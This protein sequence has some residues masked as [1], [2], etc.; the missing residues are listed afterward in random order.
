MR[1]A[2]CPCVLLLLSRAPCLQSLPYLSDS[3]APQP[4]PLAKSFSQGEED[5]EAVPGP[6]WEGEGLDDTSAA[7]RTTLSKFLPTSRRLVQVGWFPVL[8]AG[9]IQCSL[10]VIRPPPPPASVSV[11]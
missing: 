11:L 1:C 10:Q 2:T 7:R 3:L 9:V 6:S 4:H 5:E 8:W